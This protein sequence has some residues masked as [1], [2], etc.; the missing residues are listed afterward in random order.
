MSKMAWAFCDSLDD[1]CWVR[2]WRK[3]GQEEGFKEGALEDV[4]SDW[5]DRMME[6]SSC[7]LTQKQLHPAHSMKTLEKS[8][9]LNAVLPHVKVKNQIL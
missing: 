3:R 9:A 7:L 5:I 8:E 2:C 1:L 6:K 4:G